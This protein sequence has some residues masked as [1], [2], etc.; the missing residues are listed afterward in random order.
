M[1]HWGEAEIIQ[2]LRKGI[3]KGYGDGT[4]KPDQTISRLEVTSIIARTFELKPSTVSLPFVDL[5]DTYAPMV[6]E[7]KAVYSA[8][9]V[10]GDGSGNFKPKDTITREQVALMLMRVFETVSGIPY[11]ASELV[12]YEDVSNLSEESKRAIS[13]L[14]ENDV[15]DLAKNY[16]PHR[17]LTRAEAA[18]IFNKIKIK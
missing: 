6:E 14:Y 12:P 3:F 11:V 10:L 1:G 15:V 17:G 13:Y 16:N 8:G 7:L 9:I 4:F 5:A 2:S 18:K